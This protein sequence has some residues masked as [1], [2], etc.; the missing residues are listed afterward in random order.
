MLFQ[1]DVTEFRRLGL[2][3]RAIRSIVRL[4][5]WRRSRS[6]SLN[7]DCV[8]I[9]NGMRIVLNDRSRTGGG[10]P[11]VEDSRVGVDGRQGIL[12]GIFAGMSLPYLIRNLKT[13]H[14]FR[15]C[16][17]LREAALHSS[18]LFVENETRKTSAADVSAS[19]GAPF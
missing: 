1:I 8:G 12:F 19:M 7:L 15:L 16:E 4:Y 2:N 13:T 6:S 17:I 3:A 5:R 11:D 10:F 14:K 18:S 9:K